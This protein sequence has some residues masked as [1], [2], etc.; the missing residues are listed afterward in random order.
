[1][2][3]NLITALLGRPFFS[4]GMVLNDNAN[5]LGGD[6]YSAFILIVYAGLMFYYDENYMKTIRVQT[7]LFNMLG[8]LSL[9]V[10][11]SLTGMISYGLLLLAILYRYKT[12]IKSL[13]NSRN[14]LFLGF[15]IVILIS[16]FHIDKIISSF[17][18][19]IEKTGFNGRN[20]IW[21]LSIK[22]I[23]KKPLLGYG[24]LTQ[25]QQETWVIAGA[26]H[27][28]NI[29][30]Q[31]PFSVGLVGTGF[32]LMYIKCIFSG[33]NA[34]RN[35]KIAILLYTISAFLLCSIFDFYIGLVYMYLLLDI[36]WISKYNL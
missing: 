32:F 36:I 15:I 8:L 4:S 9:I 3:L 22:A 6:N 10:S 18:Y 20:F 19:S 12:I 13:L 21:P 27:T 25:I 1:M 11:F 23:A 34:K 7:W 31:F 26:N 16:Y 29:L 2:V 17:L 30:L 14:I 5:F 24:G 35:K 33:L 28:H